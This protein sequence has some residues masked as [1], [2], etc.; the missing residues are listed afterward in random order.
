L[1]AT[2][3]RERNDLASGLRSVSERGYVILFRYAG[4]QFQVIRIVHGSRDLPAVYRDTR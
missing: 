4:D 3:G 2:L 1:P